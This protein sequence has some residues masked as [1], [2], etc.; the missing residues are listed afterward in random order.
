MCGEGVR[1]DGVVGGVGEDELVERLVGC[2][3]GLDEDAVLDQG[4]EGLLDGLEGGVEVR[5]G[6]AIDDVEEHVDDVAVLGEGDCR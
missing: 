2:G 5:A 3:V 6:E 4:G 1:V